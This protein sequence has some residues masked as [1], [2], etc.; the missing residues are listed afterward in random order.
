MRGESSAPLHRRARRPNAPV[1]SGGR[2]CGALAPRPMLA[3]LAMP[4]IVVLHR[5]LAS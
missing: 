5:E 1:R 4:A 3:M 2:A